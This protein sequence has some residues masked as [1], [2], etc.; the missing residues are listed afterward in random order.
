MEQK[1]KDYDKA[2]QKIND[3]KLKDTKP[4]VYGG[5]VSTFNENA[6]EPTMDEYEFEKFVAE[7]YNSQEGDLH[8]KDGITCEFCNNKGM[9]SRVNED[10][11]GEKIYY[12]AVHVNCP[13]CAKSRSNFWKIKSNYVGKDFSGKTSKDYVLTKRWQVPLKASMN[14]YLKTYIN[15]PHKHWYGVFGTAGCGK[16][17]L[18]G[19]I[20]N[21]LGIKQQKDIE[22]VYWGNFINDVKRL[23]MA[24]DTT[25]ASNLLYDIQN[26]EVL[27][28]DEFLSDK[29]TETDLEYAKEII[30]YRYNNDL[31][32]IITSQKLFG[33]LV[34]INEPIFSRFYVKANNGKFVVDRPKETGVNMN[35][36]F[37]NLG[38][39]NVHE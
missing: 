4:Y 34:E 25:K 16:T 37:G 23:I 35:Y 39:E 7:D 10:V 18:C 17:T 28:I 33:E 29:V 15:E 38:G 26:T 3:L 31:I 27:F 32:T 30:N 24:K 9:I 19:I 6:E 14:D 20:M 22:I 36:R 2:L 8:L 12:K 21:Y 1:I 11:C 5:F 13:H